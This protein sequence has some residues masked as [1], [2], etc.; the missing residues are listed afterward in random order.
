MKDKAECPVCWEEL[1]DKGE[2]DND[3]CLSNSGISEL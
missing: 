3:N 2:C 1:N